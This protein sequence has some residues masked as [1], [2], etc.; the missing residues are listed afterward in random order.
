MQK[1]AP[2]HHEGLFA[3]FS[4]ARNSSSWTF[5][6]EDLIR[7]SNRRNSA[8]SSAIDFGDGLGGNGITS[9]IGRTSLG[10]IPHG[11]SF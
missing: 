6:N 2:A 10:A 11:V 7:S 1:K 4:L 8:V 5:C 3:Y 9:D